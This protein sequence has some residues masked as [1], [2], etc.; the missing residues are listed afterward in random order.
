MHGDMDD[1]DSIVLTRGQFVGF[2][3]ASGPAGAV[4]QAL[5]LTKHLLVV[6]TSMKDDNF[7]RLIH[8][9]AAYRQRLLN[10]NGMVVKSVA[11]A[12][13]LKFGTV[14]AVD[15]DPARRALHA[16]YFNWQSMSGKNVPERAR[17]LEIF[18]DAVAMFAASDNSWLLDDSFVYLHTDREKELAERARALARDVRRECS[19]NGAWSELASELEGFG[20]ASISEQ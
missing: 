19:A 4:L 13:P 20:A 17:Q 1:S 15:E 6:G 18:L 14:L 2:N 8:E 10:K 16:Q 3:G 12:E 5:L 7:L 9:V 11:S